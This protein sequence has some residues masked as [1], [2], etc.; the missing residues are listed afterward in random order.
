MSEN[1]GWNE[2]SKH[3]LLELERLNECYDKLD[4]KTN[5]LFTEIATLK[6]KSGVWGLI[7]GAIPVGIGLV[8]LIIRKG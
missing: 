6:V 3:V 7:G 5:K 4:I 2:W 8:I 1:N